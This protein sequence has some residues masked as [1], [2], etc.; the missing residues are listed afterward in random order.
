[1]INILKE[2][3]T[4]DGALSSAR[5]INLIGAVTGTG[6]IVYFAYLTTLN[7]EMFGAYLAYCAG[8]YGMGKYITR[9]YDDTNYNYGNQRFED[10][11]ADSAK[12]STYGVDGR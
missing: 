7:T 1:M 11:G 9:K 3:I 8:V 10:T 2:L 5:F 4:D 12:Y 6:V